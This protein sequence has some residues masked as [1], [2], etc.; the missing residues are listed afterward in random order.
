MIREC[1]LD[2]LQQCTDIAFLRNNQPESNSAYCPKSKESI[3]NDF[4]YIINNPDSILLG[5]YDNDNLK[6]VMGCFVNPDNNWVD[7][8]GPFFENEWNQDNAM[9]MYAYAKSKLTNAQRFNFYFDIRNV[10][11]HKLMESLSAERNDNEYILVLHKT[12]YMPQPIEHNIIAYNDDFKQDVI[13][14]KNNTWPDSYITDNDL[15][16]SINKD[17]DVFC[18]LD[19]SGAFVGYGVLK[20]YDDGNQTTAEVFAVA[21]HARGKGYGWALLNTVVDCSFNKYNAN[22]IDLVVDR[23]NTHA[24]DLYY[25][26]GFK[27]DVENAVYCIMK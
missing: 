6:S 8:S 9:A 20:R 19:E 7:C 1:N 18:A 16:N 11:L 21:E 2:D 14:L 4:V 25:S 10:N 26:C 3:F 24:R 27:L 13:E 12:N 23:L 22:V 15:I 17:R 5:F